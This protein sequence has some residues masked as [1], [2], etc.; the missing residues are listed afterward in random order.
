V[1]RVSLPIF[2]LLFF[3]IIAGTTHAAWFQ[4]T[5]KNLIDPVKEGRLEAVQEMLEAGADVDTR[6]EHGS[7][8]LMWA[9]VYGHL[10][11]AEVLLDKGADVNSQD[12]SGS[13]PLLLAT[14]ARRPEIVR[15]LLEKGAKANTP[16][17][18]GWTALIYAARGGHTEIAQ[19]LLEKSAWRWSLSPLTLTHQMV[20]LLLIEQLYRATEI[21]AATSY[22]K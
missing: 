12:E 8:A 22:H 4:S 18:H 1:R 10:E 15:L 6:D 2:P 5:N 7:T 21:D 16:N 9:A 19:M 3:L 20:R 17:I 14:K 11:I 13:T